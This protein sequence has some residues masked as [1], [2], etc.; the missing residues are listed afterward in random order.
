MSVGSVG[1]AQATSPQLPPTIHREGVV[2]DATTGEPIAAAKITVQAEIPGKNAF[3]ATVDT[4]SA[5]RFHIDAPYMLYGQSS[6]W[7]SKPGYT[8]KDQRLGD[9][10]RDPS[11]D[12]YERHIVFRL[13]AL[14]AVAPEEKASPQVEIPVHVTDR[15]GAT[16]AGL[17]E[18]DFELWEDGVAQTVSHFSVE[19]AP[20]SVGLVF[21]CSGSMQDKI[22]RAAEVA[23]SFLR[24]ANPGD[25]FFLVDFSDGPK[26]VSPFTTDAGDVL[27]HILPTGAVGATALLDAIQLSLKQ[28]KNAVNPRKALVVLSDGGDNRSGHSRRE[29]EMALVE[30]DVQV[31]A[32]GL[33]SAGNS[34]KLSREERDGLRLLQELSDRT[35]GGILP[36]SIADGL[37]AIGD[38]ISERIDKDLRTQYVLGYSPTDLSRDGKYHRIAVKVNRAGLHVYSQPGY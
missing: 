37:P 5:G 28:M 29:V 38:A 8:W 21:D 9:Q 36:V 20:L 17:T 1:Y 30:S 10:R 13:L 22:G 24:T 14:G 15:L 31:Y 16:V 18:D 7:A 6:L 4:D 25:E 11:G 23:R 27:A 34:Q 3:T 2:L 33:Y 26:L 12:S 19:E 35:G 32:V